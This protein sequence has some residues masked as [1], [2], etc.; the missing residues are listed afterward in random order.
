MEV[1][2][3]PAGSYL[4]FLPL[5]PGQLDIWVPLPETLLQLSLPLWPIPRLPPLAPPR[6]KRLGWGLKLAGELELDHLRPNNNQEGWDAGGG[7]GYRP[8]VGFF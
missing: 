2:L 3:L 4:V 5:G 1:L 7:W 8:G 6:P